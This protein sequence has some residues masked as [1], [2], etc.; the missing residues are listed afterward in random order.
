MNIVDIAAGSNDF[1]ILVTALN[2]AGLTDTV[3]DADDITVFAPTDAAFTALAVDLGF[4]GDT[5]DET[6]VFNHIA[7]A[8]TELAE[9]DDPIPLLTDRKSV[10]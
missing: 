2:T 6:A 3:R 10:V 7:G 1:N 5:S 9:D 8:L 4:D